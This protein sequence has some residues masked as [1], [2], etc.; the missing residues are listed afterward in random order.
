M[1]KRF[2]AALLISVV[3]VSFKSERSCI[4][5]EMEADSINTPNRIEV[6]LSG[7]NDHDQEIQSYIT[8]NSHLFFPKGTYVI[9]NFITISNVTNLKISGEPGTVFT[10]NQNKI[11]TISGEINNLE[12]EGITFKSTK[13]SAVDDAEGLVFIANYGDDDIMDGLKIHNCRFSIP[14][15][16]ANGIKLVSEGTNSSAKNISITYNKFENIGR[17]AIEFQNHNTL[18]APR[19]S[20]FDISYNYFY[21]VGTIQLGPAPACVSVSGHSLNGK[22]NYNKFYDMHMES[23]KYI[24]YGIENAGTIGLETV[25]NYMQSSTYGF[26]GLLASGSLKKSWMIKDNVFELSGGKTADKNKIRGMELCNLD[27]FIVTGN[28]ISTDGMAIMLVNCTS[29]RITNNK[30]KVKSGNAIY[31]RAGCTKNVIT[32]NDID[33]SL[34]TDNGVVLFDGSETSHNVVS[35]NNLLKTGRRPGSYVNVNGANNNK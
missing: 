11:I 22:I 1:I 17:M 16:Q 31:L 33:A 8:S 5:N 30:I 13:V 15:S 24:Y 25:G 21:N 26:T 35:L 10:S 18:L 3:L 4:L 29:G 34:G 23:S 14:N 27:D 7:I 20:E 19:F 9:N 28:T 2:F 6:R 32:R 12:I